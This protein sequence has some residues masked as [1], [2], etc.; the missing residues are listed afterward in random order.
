MIKHIVFFKFKECSKEVV[1][2]SK[3][4]LMGLY[5]KVPQLKSVDVGADLIHS[6]RSYDLALITTFESLDDLAGY[7]VD[8]EHQKVSIY[9]RSVSQSIVT[10][11]FE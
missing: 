4:L 5:G 11:D 6:D 9:L 10:V 3:S 2:K 7:Q 1:E 8:A